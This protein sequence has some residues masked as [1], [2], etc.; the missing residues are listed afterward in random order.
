MKDLD[1]INKMMKEIREKF[2]N[3]VIMTATQPTRKESGFTPRLDLGNS[4]LDIV[5]I[6]YVNLIK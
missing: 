2:P 5:I 4:G 1:K 6:D 3:F